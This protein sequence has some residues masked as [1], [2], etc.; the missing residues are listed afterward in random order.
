MVIFEKDAFNH[1]VEGGLERGK[2]GSVKISQ[3]LLQLRQKTNKK[4]ELSNVNRNTKEIAE[5]T[6]SLELKHH[7]M[8]QLSFCK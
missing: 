7:T 5:M 4:L 8:L 1:R 3:L 2:R 6:L